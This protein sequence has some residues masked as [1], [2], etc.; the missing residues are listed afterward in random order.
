MLVATNFAPPEDTVVA[1]FA[2][3]VLDIVS[4][5]LAVK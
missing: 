2:F 3:V 4:M 1:G 5:L